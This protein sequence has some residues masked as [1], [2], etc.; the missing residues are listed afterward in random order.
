MPASTF[1][2]GVSVDQVCRPEDRPDSTR[3]SSLELGLRPGRTVRG[4][5]DTGYS[6]AYSSNIS[7]RSPNPRRWP[8]RSTPGLVFDRL[9]ASQLSGRDRVRGQGQA[10][11]LVPQ[12]HPRFR[13][14]R[15]PRSFKGTPGSRPTDRK[16]DEYLTARSVSWKSG[17]R[18]ADMIVRRSSPSR[19][20]S[21]VPTRAF[22]KENNREH[23]RLDVRPHGPGLPGGRDAGQRP[24]C[25]RQRGE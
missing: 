24:S 7:W 1:K 4:N 22:P 10:R 16:V 12:E 6:C 11:P 19:G 14:S 9:F 2:V 8:R 23:I 21:S 18:K 5:C 20:A 17:W 3:F 25:L 13:G 15:T